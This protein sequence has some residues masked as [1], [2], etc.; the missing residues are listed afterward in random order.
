M[1]TTEWKRNL[2]RWLC[3]LSVTLL[4][5]ATPGF[6]E[7]SIAK[8]LLTLRTLNQA[9]NTSTIY[10]RLYGGKINAT[11]VHTD[12]QVNQA[13]PDDTYSLTLDDP[14]H[15]LDSVQCLPRTNKEPTDI[16]S[17]KD[18]FD[19]CV[20]D[21]INQ[22]VKILFPASLSSAVSGRDAFQNHSELFLVTTAL[23]MAAPSRNETTR[24]SN[25]GGLAEHEWF[26]GSEISGNAWQGLYQM[27]RAPISFHG[28]YARQNDS[29]DTNSG[30]FSADF[31]PSFSLNSELQWRVGFDARS[32]IVYS[33][34]S[35]LGDSP[36]QSSLSLGSVDYGGGIWTSVRKDISRVR[37]GG[38]TLFQ[39]SQSY[40]PS[41]A[42]NDFEF[43]SKA[44]G[45]RPVA[46]D[47]GYGGLFGFLASENGSVNGKFLE[48]RAVAPDNTNWPR[49]PARM[50]MVGY[51]YAFGGVT[52]IDFGYKISTGNG[53]TA[54]SIFF[55]GNFR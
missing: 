46:Y 9:T 6:A 23:G 39:G 11:I 52:P 43:V 41:F 26:S 55:Q 33:R 42:G 3:L 38:A 37:L 13:N 18:Y 22:I 4:I 19:G 30:T 34:S 51:S 10:G 17:N 5:P 47:I 40:F 35:P 53:I 7:D 1:S 31:H 32:G 2:I 29:V 28:R 8:T 36:G 49:P 45:N 54:H 21:H 20:K 15:R 50:A 16:R 48:T 24:R 25:M 14:R 44:M 12:G 27:N